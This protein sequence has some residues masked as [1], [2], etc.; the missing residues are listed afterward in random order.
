[1]NEEESDSDSELDLS[2]T[3][4]NSS[5]SNYEG[6]KTFPKLINS[7]FVYISKK[8]VILSVIKIQIPTIINEK[9]NICFLSKEKILKYIQQNKIIIRNKNK[10]CSNVFQKSDLDETKNKTLKNKTVKYHIHELVLYIAGEEEE[11]KSISY[12]NDVIINPTDENLHK[13]NSLYFL[14]KE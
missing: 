5:S 10:T 1:M 6:K 3:I 12:L 4:T 2:W 8:N 13:L 7:F 14:M 11:A 9:D